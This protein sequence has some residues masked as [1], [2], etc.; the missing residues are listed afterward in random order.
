MLTYMRLGFHLVLAQYVLTDTA[1]RLWYKVAHDRGD[2]ILMD[3][4]VAEGVSMPIEDLVRAAKAIHADEITLPDVV[5][6]MRA[7]IYAVARAAPEV[8]VHMRAVCPHGR[9]WGEWEECTKALVRIGCAT[10]CIGRYDN[11]PGGRIPALEIIAKHQ[12]HWNHHIHL[13]GCSAPPLEATRK[14][15]KAAPWIRSMDTGAPIAYAQQDRSL[16][17]GPHASLQ[18]NAGFNT[19][20]ADQNISRLLDVCNGE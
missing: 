3:N 1:Y 9:N 12:W 4:G 2:F 5:G 17:G 11:L 15:L 8:P 18:W 16:E 19:R 10:I 6:D 13:F 20:Y 14:E 7:T